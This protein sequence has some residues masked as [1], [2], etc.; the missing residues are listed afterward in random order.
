MRTDQRFD[1]FYAATV[2]SV[3]RRRLNRA[4]AH[5]RHAVADEVTSRSPSP[6]AVAVAAALALLPANKRR[7]VVLPYLADL[8]VADV[9]REMNAPRGSVKG[10]LSS[11][12]S[13]LLPL[14]EDGYRTTNRGQR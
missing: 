13:A 5:Q 6:D 4:S 10:W 1:D 8:S 9:A 7:A 3:V 2:A 14:L 12:R 11:G